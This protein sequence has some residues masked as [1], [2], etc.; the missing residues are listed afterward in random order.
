M[1]TKDQGTTDNGWTPLIVAAQNGHLE[2]VRFPVGSGANKEQGTTDNGWTPLIVAAQNGHLEIVRFLEESGANKRP[3]HNW[4]WI[5]AS[6]RGSS[7]WAP[8]NCSI[9]GYFWWSLVPTKTKAWLIM[10][11]RFYNQKMK[12]MLVEMKPK[13]TWDSVHC[14]A[15]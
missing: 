10:E 7:E 4:W 5:D 3:R 11:E 15:S 14:R 2:I 13:K 12:Q 6:Y 9:S 8:W 1:P